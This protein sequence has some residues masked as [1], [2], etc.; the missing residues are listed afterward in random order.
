MI[1]K[2]HLPEN[3]HRLKHQ[4]ILASLRIDDETQCAMLFGFVTRLI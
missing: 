4:T 1:N 2:I 3:S